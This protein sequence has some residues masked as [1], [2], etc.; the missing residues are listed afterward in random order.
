MQPTGA[1]LD[2][3]DGIFTLTLRRPAVL[4]A[5]N[6][7]LCREVAAAL[8][9]VAA[10]P[11][12]RVLVLTG[13]G[14]AFCAG[15]DLR[16]REGATLE[17]LWAH[18]RSIAAIPDALERL[19]V[20]AIAAIN[21]PALGGGCE[22]A[23]G[24]DLR[25][26]AETAVLGCPEVTRGIMPAAGATQR[27]PRLIG[28]SRAMALVYTGAHVTAT[29]AYRIGLVDAVV[30]GGRLMPAVLEVA[31][32]IAANAPLAI[33]A[34]KQAIRAGIARGLEEGLELEGRLQRQLYETEDCR[35]GIAA[36]RERRAARW[37]GR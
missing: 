35:E 1:T 6:V 13:E 18:N 30:P 16:E 5:L 31:G 27:L 24:C 26:A 23:L 20:P 37:V 36:F 4:N 14:R 19:P 2:G 9:R 33:R 22:L 28:S 12:A 32:V 29:E 11:G 3:R 34:A 15:A 8:A 21:G 17:A 10:D 25:W 7:A